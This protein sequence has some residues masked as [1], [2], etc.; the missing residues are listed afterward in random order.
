MT[1]QK[2]DLIASQIEDLDATELTKDEEDDETEMTVDEPEPEEVRMDA[3]SPDLTMDA[4]DTDATID[5]FGGIGRPLSP[6]IP[7]SQIIARD[8]AIEPAPLAALP[9]NADAAFGQW[10]AGSG[11]PSLN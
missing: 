2:L 1:S 10:L 11:L 4:D 6:K 5:K 3:D 8:I 9:A 7:A